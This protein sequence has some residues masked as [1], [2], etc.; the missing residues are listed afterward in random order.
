[1]VVLDNGPEVCEDIIEGLANGEYVV[2]L[3][4]KHKGEMGN[5]E[6]QIYGYYQGLRSE[7]IENDKYSEETD[8][9]WTVALKET[10]APKAAMF[11]FNT[12]SKTTATQF[13]TLTEE[14]VA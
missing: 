3:R 1:M 9:G 12:D 6:Y 5:A 14:P 11:M 8:G 2:I 10:G 13:V 7:T 4:N